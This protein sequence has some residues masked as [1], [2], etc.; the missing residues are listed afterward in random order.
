MA[1]DG[2][3]FCNG[4]IRLKDVVFA[5]PSRDNVLNDLSLVIEKGK[6]TALVGPRSDCIVFT[7]ASILYFAAEEANPPFCR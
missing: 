7:L 5:Y 6:T 4:D 1:D 2:S 3:Q